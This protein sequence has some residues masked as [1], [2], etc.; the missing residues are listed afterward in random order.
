MRLFP[1]PWRCSF[2]LTVASLRVC[3]FFLVVKRERTGTQS[4]LCMH[5]LVTTEE[6]V[7]EVQ[8][9]AFESTLRVRLYVPSAHISAE[10]CVRRIFLLLIY[11]YCC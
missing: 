6:G 8:E 1:R 11:I 4:T 2:R 3:S 7:K 10:I 5:W 9:H